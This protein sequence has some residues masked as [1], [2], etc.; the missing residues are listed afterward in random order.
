M[1]ATVSR[2]CSSGVL[3]VWGMVLLYFQLSGRIA[4]YLHPAFHPFV[5]ITGGVL[6]FISVAMLLTF[7]KED[8]HKCGDFCDDHSHASGPFSGGVVSLLILIVPLLGATKISQS[9]FGATMVKNRGVVSDIADL[10]GYSPAFEPA[11][12][13]PDGTIGESTLL[14]PSLYL[15]KNDSGQIL[16]EVIDL[17]Y[18]AGDP[19]LR[20]DFENQEVELV[21]QFLPARTDNPEGD[22]FRLVRM[23]VMCCA[24]DARPVA[25]S[26][27]END[28]S[29]FPEMTWVKVHG[30]VSFPLVGGRQTPLVVADSV[31]ETEPPRESFFY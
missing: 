10:P 26:V 27:Q 2:F 17:V 23:F 28:V 22:R 24:A 4:S 9:S 25:I 11:L 8:A 18:A 15:K 29:A 1:N 6:I 19:D 5:A 3:M 16:A 31:T 20:R 7:P 12:P 13:N 30:K 21:G 14:D